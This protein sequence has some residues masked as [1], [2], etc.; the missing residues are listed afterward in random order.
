M[1]LTGDVGAGKSTFM[2]ILSKMGARTASADLV[3]KGL[4]MRRD[5]RDAFVSRW[6]CLPTKADGSIDA[7]A[8][9]KKVFSDAEEYHFLCSVLH[10]TTWEMLR[11]A[12]TDDGVWVLEVPLLFESKVPHWIDGTVYLRSPRDVRVSRVA[13]RGWDDE[14]LLSRERWLLDGEVKSRMADWVLDNC[15]TL[16][17]L[18]IAARGLY[19]EFRRL[20][21]VLLGNLTFGSMSEA[22]RFANEMVERRIAACCRMKL[23]SS[24]YRWEGAVCDEDEAELTFKT[25]EDRLED[26]NELLQ[27][28]PY[29]MPALML[30][31]PHR[32]PLGLRRWVVESCSP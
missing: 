13:A 1:A 9:S 21:S 27:S 10:P 31:R 3:A 11:D 30:Q 18:E 22:R 23:V 25:I 4:W 26:L 5:V 8:I 24:V 2:S 32:M 12:V 20:N 6:G 17:D 28:H 14:E 29:Q 15:G 19:E 16:E 7:A